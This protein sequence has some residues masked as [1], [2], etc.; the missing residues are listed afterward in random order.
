MKKILLFILKVIAYAI[1]GLI[2]PAMILF[3]IIYGG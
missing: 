3:C 2:W 1:A